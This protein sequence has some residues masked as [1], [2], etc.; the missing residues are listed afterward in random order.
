MGVWEPTVELIS[1]EGTSISINRIEWGGDRGVWGQKRR[2]TC[3]DSRNKITNSYGYYPSTHP[4]I[5]HSL[6]IFSSANLC[7]KAQTGLDACVL[8]RGHLCDLSRLK[9]RLISASV[10]EEQASFKKDTPKSHGRLEFTGEL[11]G[12]GTGA[13]HLRWKG[14]I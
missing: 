6:F 12:G 3:T 10:T 13:L 9:V 7:Y 2:Q 1:D 14:V 11:P 8:Q 4:S 5:H